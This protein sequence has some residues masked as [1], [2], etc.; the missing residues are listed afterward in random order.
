[1]RLRVQQRVGRAASRTT[2][3]VYLRLGSASLSLPSSPVLARPFKAHECA[4]TRV[5]YPDD[6]SVNRSC[7]LLGDSRPPE[8]VARYPIRSR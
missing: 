5:A 6:D 8:S 2:L 3:I 4:A 1:M 7:W